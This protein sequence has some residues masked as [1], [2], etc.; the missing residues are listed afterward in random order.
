MMFGWDQIIFRD[1]LTQRV[2]GIEV[3]PKNDIKPHISEEMCEC[4]PT[5]ETVEGVP[6]LVH[7]SFDGREKYERLRDQ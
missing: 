5:L 2:V 4:C 1:R 6:M 7:N 3:E